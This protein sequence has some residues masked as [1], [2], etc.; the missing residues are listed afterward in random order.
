MKKFFDNVGV[1]YAHS[2]KDIHL[3]MQAL[4]ERG[5]RMTA[6]RQ[7]ILNVLLTSTRPLSPAELHR[8]AREAYRGVGLVTVYRTI[9]A[10]ID[11]GV[12]RRVHREDGCHGYVYVGYGHR[13]IAVC[14]VCGKVLIF[15]GTEDVSVLEEKLEKETGF[16]VDDHLLQFV[17]V[18]AECQAK[19]KEG[20]KP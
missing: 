1:G 15:S 5:Y 4:R 14:R 13:H 20:A 7:A 10:L 18:C 9:E 19:E 11:L 12:L 6:A 17:G 3:I 16:R 8:K 2:M